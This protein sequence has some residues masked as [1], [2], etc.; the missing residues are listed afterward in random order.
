MTSETVSSPPPPRPTTAAATLFSNPKA[1][2]GL[3]IVLP[4]VCVICDP[5]VFRGTTIPPL[6]GSYRISAYGYMAFAML[7]LAAWLTTRRLPSLLCGFLIGGCVFALVLGIVLLPISAIG[8]F[9][10]IGILGFSPFLTAATFWYCAMNA[11]NAAGDRFKPLLA[12][13]AFAFFV[14]LPIGIQSYV[15]HVTE[16]A[17][18]MLV[19]GSDQSAE[20]AIRRLEMLGPV[21]D[22]DVL[23]WRFAE[24]K[25]EEARNRLASAYGRLTG[26]D[27]QRR[28]DRLRD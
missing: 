15:V 10:I 28:L 18:T 12:A 9:A 16:Q 5:L 1:A 7:A 17:M 4:L 8:L 11:R 3:G 27:I 14:A 26:N 25:S 20:R 19:N 2:V 22:P 24:A 23:A 21:I 13:L 6:L